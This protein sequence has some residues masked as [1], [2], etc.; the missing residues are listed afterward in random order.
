MAAL[1]TLAVCASQVSLL[2]IVMPSN[3]K[4]ETVVRVLPSRVRVGGEGGWGRER[5]AWRL[6]WLY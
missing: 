4:D 3:L 2:S 5:K 1:V 6:T